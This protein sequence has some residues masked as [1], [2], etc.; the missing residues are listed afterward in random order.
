M[1][2]YL[3]KAPVLCFQG[4]KYK[5][6]TV[7]ETDTPYITGNIHSPDHEPQQSKT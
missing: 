6:L 4:E 7:Q 2:P 5:T 1:S 3:Y